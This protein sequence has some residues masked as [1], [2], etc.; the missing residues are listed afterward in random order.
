VALSLPKGQATDINEYQATTIARAVS[1]LERLG[2]P[3]QAKTKTK[4]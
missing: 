4:R 1:P 2:P 3:P